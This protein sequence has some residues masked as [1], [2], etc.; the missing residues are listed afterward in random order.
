MKIAFTIAV[1]S[2]TAMIQAQQLYRWT[3]L[4][5]DS[6][7]DLSAPAGINNAG[8][9]TGYFRNLVDGTISGYITTAGNAPTVII[10]PAGGNLA[11]SALSPSGVVAGCIS[12]KTPFIGQANS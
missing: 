4:I 3:A 5:P 2:C 9:S 6:V 10:D 7:G 8:Q 12:S 11:P 1:V